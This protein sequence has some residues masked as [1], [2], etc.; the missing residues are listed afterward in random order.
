MAHFLQCGKI[1][2]T[3]IVQ[4][5]VSS[6]PMDK[7]LSLIVPT[8]NEQDNIKPLVEKIAGV[9]SGN[10]YEIVFI[11]DNSTD[12]TVEL[13]S[14]LS[15][16]YPVRVIV[17]RNERGLAS[18]VAKGFRQAKGELLGVIDADLQHPPEV[19]IHLVQAIKDGADIAIASRYVPGG[20]IPHWGLVRRVISKGAVILAHLALPSTGSI[21]DPMSGCFMLNREVLKGANLNPTGYKI[22]L[23]ILIEGKFQKVTEVPYTFGNRN[24]GESKLI[25]RQQID[26]LMHLYSL[27]RRK[28]EITRFLKFCLVGA[29]GVLVNE[30]LLWILK[31]FAGL[32]L[33][34]SSAISIE[35]SIISNFILNDRFTFRDRRLSG[36][37]S[38][39]QHLYR[40]NM[41]SLAGLVINMGLLWLL[42]NVFGI[43][44]LL[45]NIISIAV[46]TLW[47]YLVNRS[48]TWKD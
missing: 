13:A 48:W 11:D 39:V 24:S 41:V 6:K 37:R 14:R 38:F 28:G 34:L 25:A 17:R 47:N 19:L 5:K 20:G 2:F 21:R 42:T 36:T 40:F 46:V 9:L 12:D 7:A 43:Y 18:A 35:A 45:S 4:K 33:L 30:G 31:G 10:N 16:K 22:L 15:P 27:M 23:E 1:P 29:S 26:Y 32:P 3:P 8:Y 44:Y